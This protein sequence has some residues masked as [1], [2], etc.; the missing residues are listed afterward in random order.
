[1]ERIHCSGNFCS[2]LCL[3]NI[4]YF[5]QNAVQYASKFEKGLAQFVAAAASSSTMYL[6]SYTGGN[7]IRRCYELPYIYLV[8]TW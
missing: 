3:M 7:Y 8:N 2:L 5:N 6:P 4:S 1:M